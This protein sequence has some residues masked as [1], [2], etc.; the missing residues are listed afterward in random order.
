MDASY[1]RY[2][3]HFIRPAGTSRGTLHRKECWFLRLV[4]GSGVTSLGEVSFIPGL[5]REGA[6]QVEAE[7]D[8]LCRMITLEKKDPAGLI[9]AVPGVL[10][11]LE[12]ALKGLEQGGTGI[13]FHSEF[14]RGMSSSMRKRA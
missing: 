13:L 9:P 4:T 7:L 6:E 5:G 3:L 8:R 11:A 2:P 10:F 1:I 14:T 12:C